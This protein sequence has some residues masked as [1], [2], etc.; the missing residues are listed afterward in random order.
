MSTTEHTAGL[1]EAAEPEP[2]RSAFGRQ[3]HDAL[4]HLYDPVYL[5]THSL[6]RLLREK[7]LLQGPHYG[8]SLRQQI[9]QALEE[10]QPSTGGEGSRGYQLLSR[11]YVEGL[12]A[13]QVQD[14]LGL[15]RRQ[16]YR[17]HN[18][19]LLA[20]VTLLSARWGL[21]TAAAVPVG[22]EGEAMPVTQDGAGR[23]RG[24]SGLPVFLTSFVGRGREMAEV[25]EMLQ[26]ARLLT[27]T[28]SGG[29]GK[30]RLALQ[31]AAGLAGEY[32][33]GVQVVELA[34]LSDPA[35]VPQTVAFALGVREEQGQSVEGA[36]LRHLRS[37]QALLV[38]D[39]CEHLLLACARLAEK[40]L[41]ECPRLH[42]LVTSREALGI[43][44]ETR[45]R[46][47][48]LSAPPPEGWQSATEVGQYEA[49]QLFCERA[50]AV[51]PSFALTPANAPAVA[52]V[53]WRLDGIPLAIELAA[54][55]AR[56]LKV[57][58]MVGRLGDRFLLL[59]G[60][61]R[62]ALRRHQTLRAT[63]DWSH[64]LLTDAERV[65]FRRLAIFSGG[66][67][68]AAAEGVC[69]GEGVDRREVLDL[70]SQLVDK[71][72]VLVEV[73]KDGTRYR[74]L[75]TIR[76]YAA[77]R[78]VAAGE[79]E[80]LGR[81]HRDWYVA[82]A[83]SELP[84]MVGSGQLRCVRR[85]EAEYANLH[86]A[87]VWSQRDPAGAEAELRLVAVSARYWRWTGRWKEA[88][89]WLGEAMGRCER[90]ASAAWARALTCRSH[91]EVSY[92]GDLDRAVAFT[93]EAVAVARSVGGGSL[94]AF[95]LRQAGVVLAVR[96]NVEKG[97]RY[98]D[99]A[100]G[101][102]RQTGDQREACSALAQRPIFCHYP[103]YP[104]ETVRDLE[105]ALVVA[106]ALGD[107]ALLAEIYYWLGL[108]FTAKEEQERARVVLVESATWARSIGYWEFFTSCTAMLG[109]IALTTGDRTGALT[110]YDEALGDELSRASDGLAVEALIRLATL[111][112]EEG[113]HEAATRLFAWSNSRQV[114]V[115]A[116]RWYRPPV[117]ILRQ[118]RLAN[119]AA[120]V[121]AREALGE[122]AFARAWEAG[123]AM[124]LEEVGEL[125]KSLLDALRGPLPSARAGG[126]R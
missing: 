68:L 23:E 77:E 42:I 30:T 61:S 96:G 2:L 117:T 109:D 69:G 27:L 19:A 65:L 78:L 76:E 119:Q 44:G 33:D 48:S 81:R 110:R 66:W 18:R 62:T 95:V 45:W 85:L 83:E 70:L 15:S 123:R 56:V 103:A 75:E 100:T 122:E 74:F 94:L 5:Q 126:G 112:V 91:L 8:Q 51:R 14:R 59:A 97:E 35:L 21:G 71:S 11:R 17:E 57:G 82:Y 52:E 86:E 79:A 39:N 108:V 120:L 4:A 7:G 92:G 72:L 40:L 60:G 80:A 31:V 36:L 37:R 47:P 104:E 34:S 125:G 29:C 111:A 115:S 32:S 43:G 107:A 99:E 16:F 88:V 124:S 49:V 20:V 38:L 105:R 73:R 25:R 26:T 102:A 90:V 54:A 24:N 12:E 6:T 50:R 58:E 28:G 67:T 98:F 113:H 118:M 53:C 63:L 13:A 114:T 89:A 22:G 41:G 46:V 9:L 55:R 101:V 64:D 3:V 10:L 1:P 87:L 121:A 116:N 93:E 84:N 106:Q